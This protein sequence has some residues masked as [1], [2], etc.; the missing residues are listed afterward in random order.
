[1]TLHVLGTGSSGNCYLFKPSKGKYLIIDCGINFKEVKKAVDFDIN[2]IGGCL[3]THSHGDH[4]KFT[5]D[6]LNAGIDVYM[7]EQNQKEIKIDNHR[8]INIKHNVK[9]KIDDFEV[10]PF[11][12]NHNVFCLGF[13]INHSESGLFVFM[14]DTYY[15]KYTFEG[16]N[17]IIVEANYS[18]KIIEHKKEN[19]LLGHSNYIHHFSLENCKDMLKA[20]DLRQVNNIVLIHLS[21]SNSDEKQFQK[22]VYELTY[23]NVHVA[24]NGMVISFY[25][26]PF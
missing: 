13:L 19:N 6:F 25:K 4:S 15:S 24:S 21:D 7:S 12:L 10:L 20:N 11:K 22:E 9:F 8:I 17:N 18:K 3:Q 26:T 23:K 5:I 14:T 2:S 16:L 1:M